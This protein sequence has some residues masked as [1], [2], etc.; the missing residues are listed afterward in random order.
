MLQ[1]VEALAENDLI[2]LAARIMLIK[3]SIRVANPLLSRPLMHSVFPH[4]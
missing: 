4:I 3:P 2:D 1:F